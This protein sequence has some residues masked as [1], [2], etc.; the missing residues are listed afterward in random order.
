MTHLP[1][2]TIRTGDTVMPRITL[3]DLRSGEA[4][5]D[6]SSVVFKLYGPPGFTGLTRSS[7]SSG[8][9]INNEDG[10]YDAYFNVGG[11]GSYYCT[12]TAISLAG[13]QKSEEWRFEVEP[14]KGV[15]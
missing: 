7:L 10:T 9:V 3:I 13:Y 5:P 14:L 2:D 4:I 12:A 15:V 6:A 11:P 8:E 1:E